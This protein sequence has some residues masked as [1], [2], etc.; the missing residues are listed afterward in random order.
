MIV[1][2]FENDV[3]SIPASIS[4][5]YRE[6]TEIDLKVLLCLCSDAELRQCDNVAER[7]SKRLK[8]RIKL[9]KESINYWI[10]TGI[11]AD[12]D[13]TQDYDKRESWT[14][15]D[16]EEQ[17]GTEEVREKAVPV[18]R[19]ANYTGEEIEE[20]LDGG[21]GERRAGNRKRRAGNGV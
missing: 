13:V 21:N 19:E 10:E 2:K 8:C 5:Y 15:T 18:K 12:E 3:I 7:V 11:I 20:L 4:K 14:F 16:V 6:A 1:L 9:V 17:P